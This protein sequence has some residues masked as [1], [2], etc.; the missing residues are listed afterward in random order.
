MC[1]CC[2]V[3]S[4]LQH[5]PGPCSHHPDRLVMFANPDCRSIRMALKVMVL[6]GLGP[7]WLGRGEGGCARLGGLVPGEML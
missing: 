2:S 4:G 6:Q 3:R 5:V 7:H 1:M